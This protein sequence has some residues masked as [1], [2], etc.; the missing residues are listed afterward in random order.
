MPFGQRPQKPAT[1]YTALAPPV[2]SFYLRCNGGTWSSA[3]NVAESRVLVAAQ[4][5]LITGRY[6]RPSSFLGPVAV[7][8][9]DSEPPTPRG[10]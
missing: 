9:W 1:Q 8:L 5:S 2:E 10:G 3:I 7:F 6:L 4:Y